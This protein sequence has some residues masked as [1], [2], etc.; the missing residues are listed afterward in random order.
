LEIKK[1]HFIFALSII[2]VMSET[3]KV[4]RLEF[5]DKPNKN[6][7][8]VK[9]G[10][11]IHSDNILEKMWWY[12]EMLQEHANLDIYPNIHSDGFKVLDCFFCAFESLDSL[13]NWFVNFFQYLIDWGFVIRE[14]TLNKPYLNGKSG[15]QVMFIDSSVV[16]SK[17]ILL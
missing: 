5:E 15:K 13:E 6:S 12:E 1:I 2:K 8:I 11:Y 7:K 3:F 14:Y 16:E 4:Y 10:C 17:I 9:M